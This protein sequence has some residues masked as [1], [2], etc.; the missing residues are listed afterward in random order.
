MNG[1]KIGLDQGR[2]TWRHNNIVKYIADSI[3]KSKYTV[4]S[5]IDEYLGANGGTIPVSMTVTNLKP[6]IVIV[7]ETEKTADIVEITV[8]FESNIH[9]RHTYKTEKYAHLLQDITSYK[10]S[11]TALEVGSHGYLTKD[12]IVRIKQI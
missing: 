3:D 10:P 6:D 5:D 9:T 12:N 11:V 4:H 1:C 8:P 2:W 7:S